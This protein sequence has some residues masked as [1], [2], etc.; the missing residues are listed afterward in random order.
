MLMAARKRGEQTAKVALVLGQDPIVYVVSGSRVA[1]RQGDRPV[2]E[3]AVAGGLRGQP[4][5]VV[6]LRRPTISSFR[7]TQR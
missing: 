3:L 5:E 7:P 6:K 4:V 1:N 2:D